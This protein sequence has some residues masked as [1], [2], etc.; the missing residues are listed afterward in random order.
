[1]IPRGLLLIAVLLRLT[2]AAWGGGSPK[3]IVFDGGT[4]TAGAGWAS[5]AKT[6]TFGLSTA[7]C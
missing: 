2:A 3:R 4:R 6:V 7:G 1:M 5:P